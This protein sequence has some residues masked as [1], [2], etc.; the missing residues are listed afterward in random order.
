GDGSRYAITRFI[1]TSAGGFVDFYLRV[2]SG[3]LAPWERPVLA[4]QSVVLECSVTGGASWTELGRY[5]PAA[6]MAWTRVV[7]P[8][9]PAAQT[10]HTLFRWRQLDHE[11]ACCDHWALDDVAVLVG[12]RPPVITS[13][14]AGQSLSSG[15]NVSLSVGAFGTAPLIY[16]WRR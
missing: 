10:N 1:D 4:S 16:Q 11:G 5:E 2:G 3:G 9:P 7:L 13:S 14:P 15:S 6:F 12:P 8:I